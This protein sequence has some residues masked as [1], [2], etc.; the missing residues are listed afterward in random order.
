MA[1]NELLSSR[2]IREG[3]E[4]YEKNC[5]GK[6]LPLM[7]PSAPSQKRIDVFEGSSSTKTL[8]SII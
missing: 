4:I 1:A 5:R 6:D 3:G 8:E 2:Y 7:F